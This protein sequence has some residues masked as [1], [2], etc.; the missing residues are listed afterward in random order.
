ML[1]ERQEASPIAKTSLLSKP[2]ASDAYLRESDDCL[3]K[4]YLSQQMQPRS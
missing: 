1:D 3:F 4:Y 2:R